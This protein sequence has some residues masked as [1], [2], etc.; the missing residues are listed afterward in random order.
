[1]PSSVKDR[2]SNT[3]EH[4]FHFVKQRKY[5]YNLDAIRES[6]KSSTL[7]RVTQKK[8][9]KQKGE[10]KQEILRGTPNRGNPSRCNLMVQSLAKQYVKHNLAVGRVGNFSYSDPLHTREYH[11]KGKNP[12]D[13]FQVQKQ[14]YIGNNP[15][16][17]RL[18]K[19]LYT[20][21]NPKRPHDLSHPLG[22]NPGDVVTSRFLKYSVKTGSP[23]VRARR[24]LSEGK[25]TTFVREK[26]LDVG[27]Y[28]KGKLKESGYKT[29]EL[30]EKI[31]IKKTTLDHY[32]RTDFSGQALP[33]KEVWNRL[34][35]LLDLGNYEDFINEEVRSVLPHPHPLGRNPGDF[36]SICTKPFRGAHFAV[37]PEGVC[38]KPILSSCP[39]E[40]VVLD[41]MCGSGTTLVVAAKLG[42]RYIGIDLNPEY[43]DIAKSRLERVL[44]TNKPKE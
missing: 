12:G 16:R 9:F 4:I 28:L 39:P 20:P 40:G 36:W 19:S 29:R 23:G 38:V 14:P 22:K 35:P 18:Q 43:V 30:A 41:P 1:M 32:F 27:A 8:V 2:L 6:H 34:K 5:Y 15:H 10:E 37:Y 11:P 3:Y 7:K 13:V 42:R 17:M 44:I 33:P 25:L 24:T 21:L 31:G 26:Q